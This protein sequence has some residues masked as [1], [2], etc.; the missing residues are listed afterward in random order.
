MMGTWWWLKHVS[1]SK[2]SRKGLNFIRFNWQKDF[3]LGLGWRQ[4]C[5]YF[6]CLARLPADWECWWE[7]SRPASQSSPGPCMLG[8]HLSPVGMESSDRLAAPPIA[9]SPALTTCHSS[10][11]TWRPDPCH[12]GSLM[13]WWSYRRR[14]GRNHRRDQLSDLPWTS[15]LLLPLYNPEQSTIIGS[16]EYESRIWW[17]DKI[18]K[19]WWFSSKECLSASYYHHDSMIGCRQFSCQNLHFLDK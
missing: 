6:T 12:P 16:S 18:R 17:V 4:F 14:T 1:K 7:E 15:P 11:R 19:S 3:G 5:C 13:I 8:R 9:A 2:Y 10:W